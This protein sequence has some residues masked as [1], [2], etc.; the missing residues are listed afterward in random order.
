MWQNKGDASRGSVDVAKAQCHCDRCSRSASARDKGCVCEA[1]PRWPGWPAMAWPTIAWS[2]WCKWSC[3]LTWSNGAELD[4]GCVCLA[5]IDGYSNLRPE[6]GDNT[7]SF[8]LLSLPKSHL[9]LFSSY[10]FHRRLD[11]CGHHFVGAASRL[12]PPGGAS[13]V[14]R[15]WQQGRPQ[16]LAAPGSE[17]G[18]G[19]PGGRPKA[20]GGAEGGGAVGRGLPGA[21]GG[22]GR[23][24]RPGLDLRPPPPRERGADGLGEQWLLLGERS[25]AVGP[26]PQTRPKSLSAR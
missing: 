11:P 9:S 15:C 8:H 14:E 19:W 6:C 7:T 22:T 2:E 10:L 18:R 4:C 20:V 25:R 17:W 26:P 23:R 16:A 5:C 3:L 13:P 1:V 12:D 21:A 24:G